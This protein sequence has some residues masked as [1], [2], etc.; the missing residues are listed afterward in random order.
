M[1]LLVSLTILFLLILAVIGW[2]IPED[3][4]TVVFQVV[5][6]EKI[7]RKIEKEP[8]YAENPLY[9]LFLFGPNAKTQVW[10][11][12][13]K[14]KRGL[15]HYDV[16]Y[17]DKDGDGDL[18]DPKEKFIGQYNKKRAKVGAA[19]TIQAGDL[20]VQGTDRAHRDLKFS[21]IAKTGR[22]GVGFTML[23]CGKEKISGGQARTGLDNTSWAT[24]PGR[25]PILRPTV[26][27][28]LSFAIFDGSTIPVLKTGTST[29]LRIM[30]GNR[31][32]GTD[33]LCYLSDKFLIP[34]KDR[35]FA[36]VIAKDRKGRTIETR[37]E[38]REKP[39]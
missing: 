34:G 32:S 15:E 13:D 18:T 11:V 17:L 36:T 16:L 10:A 8:V 29:R 12:L 1:R 20:S 35:I 33:T 4:D 7:E 14:S 2:D 24:S 37:S 21:T 19:M 39:C 25:A 23:W 26:E 38:I 28:P 30:I 3:K 31:G 9:A 5:D 27:G 22:K 6:F